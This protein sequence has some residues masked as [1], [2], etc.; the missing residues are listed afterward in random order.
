MIASDANSPSSLPASKRIPAG[1]GA[2]VSIVTAPP[3]DMLTFP[4]ASVASA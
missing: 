2:D 4:A 3:E 1:A